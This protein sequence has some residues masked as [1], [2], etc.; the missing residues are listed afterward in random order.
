MSIVKKILINT[1]ATPGFNSLAS[2]YYKNNIPIFMLHRFNSQEHGVKGHDPEHL[3]FTLEFLRKRKF[4]F[5]SVE[6]VANAAKQNILL[7]PRSIAFTLDDGY[8]DQIDESASI[9][10]EFDC[11]ATY[12]VVSG[13]VNDELWIWDAKIYHL[14]DTLEE[15]KLE[16]LKQEFPT[17]QFQNASRDEIATKVVFFLAE[18]PMCDIKTITQSLVQVLDYD[19]P[20]KAPPKYASTS[21]SK[22]EKLLSYGLKVAPHTYSHPILSNES[23]E[24]AK[25][26]IGRSRDDLK[27][28]LSSYSN[29]FCYPVGRPQDFGKREENIARDLQYVGAVS[30]QPGI[31]NRSKDTNLYSMPRFGFPDNREDFYQYATWIEAFKERIRRK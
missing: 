16:L 30:A 19:M 13:F 31:I 28:N 20:D 24:D 11:P 25:I 5:V 18:H 2:N 10:K 23:E 9:F 22:L 6:D 7:P 29:I 4:N 17:L 14:L 8:F 12:F 26:E 27:A 1:L 15:A 3:R 21:W